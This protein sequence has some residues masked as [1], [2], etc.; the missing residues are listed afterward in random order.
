MVALVSSTFFIPENKYFSAYLHGH[1]GQKVSAPGLLSTIQSL[2][3]FP[4][5]RL[6]H[7]A[8]LARRDASNASSFLSYIPWSNCGLRESCISAAFPPTISAHNFNRLSP[9]V[10]GISS[11]VTFPT[12]VAFMVNVIRF[13]R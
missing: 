1:I 9:V 11:P 4:I 10:F 6:N 5:A 12:S 8:F 7:P 2:L 3:S 13:D